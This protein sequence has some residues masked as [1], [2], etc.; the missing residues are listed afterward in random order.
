M[1]TKLKNLCDKITTEGQERLTAE[2]LAC[3]C[4]LKMAVAR[5]KDGK[6]YVKIDIGT[7]GRYM[8]DK[9]TGEIFGIKAYGVVNKGH[10]YGTLDTIEQYYWGDYRAV[11]I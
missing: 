5:Y 8:V 1:E 3:E 9:T 2:R 7:S 10:F 4:N 6:K 11:K